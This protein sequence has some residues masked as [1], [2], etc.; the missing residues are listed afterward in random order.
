MKP[1]AVGQDGIL[2]FGC[3]AIMGLAVG[4]YGALSS[5][6]TGGQTLLVASVIAL[7]I[8]LLTLLFGGR[9]LKVL[10]RWFAP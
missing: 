8:G 7:V 3:G 1:S 6:Q 5:G 2:R 4:G 10:M 9:L